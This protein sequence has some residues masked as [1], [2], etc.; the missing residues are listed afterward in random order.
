VSR[1][2]SNVVFAIIMQPSYEAA[3]SIAS[4]PSVSLSEIQS[5]THQHNMP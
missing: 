2:S 3:L 5:R 4:R 1:I